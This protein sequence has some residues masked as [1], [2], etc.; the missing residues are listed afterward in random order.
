MAGLQ[1]DNVSK[2]NRWYMV[3]A[4]KEPTTNILE[5]RHVLCAWIAL[6]SCQ[7]QMRC[8]WHNYVLHD[9]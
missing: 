4:A 9:I 6:D 8:A 5:S 2:V 1:G 7:R 3:N